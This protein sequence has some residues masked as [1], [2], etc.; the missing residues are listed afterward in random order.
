MNL[1]QFLL[2][3]VI[4]HSEQWQ[5]KKGVFLEWLLKR[6]LFGNI[7]ENDQIGSFSHL[8]IITV[9]SNRL[10]G[11][12]NEKSILETKK[13]LFYLDYVLVLHTMTTH[14]LRLIVCTWKRGLKF[15][16]NL[17]ETLR[18]TVLPPV[19]SLSSISES[20]FHSFLK[21]RQWRKLQAV[22]RK[23]VGRLLAHLL[24]P[25]HSFFSSFIYLSL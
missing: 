24:L 3:V 2:Q 19:E 17:S 20:V 7:F 1:G 8:V 22:C 25:L 13:S 16:L 6:F 18:N 11:Y 5:K 14:Q 12:F 9:M 15:I 21:L 4:F 10:N 23:A